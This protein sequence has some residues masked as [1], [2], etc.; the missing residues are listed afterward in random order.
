MND[1]TLTQLPLD[2][3]ELS[4]VDGHVMTTSLHIAHDFERNHRHVLET[5]KKL[6]C[7]E[8]FREP[9][10]RLSSYVSEQGKPQPMYNLTRDGFTFLVMGFTGSKAAAWKEKYIRAFNLM[11]EKLKE[12]SRSGLALVKADNTALSLFNAIKRQHDETGQLIEMT[13]QTFQTATEAKNTADEALAQI[14]EMKEQQQAVIDSLTEIPE[15]SVEAPVETTRV[16]LIKVVDS[17]VKLGGMDHQAVWRVL[18]RELTLRCHFDVGAR[19]RFAP[20]KT[21][22]QIVEEA[23]QM[24]NLYAIAFEKLETIRKGVA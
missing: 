24:E 11:E 22:L 23:G 19:Q 10:F 8:E 6:Q 5:I 4:V 12:Q 17:I 18:Y 1:Q 9:N 16:K 13:I 14:R 20:K 2:L 21:K 7:S 3:P 15:P